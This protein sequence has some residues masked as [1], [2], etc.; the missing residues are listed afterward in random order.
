MPESNILGAG[1]WLY[2]SLFASDAAEEA[3]LT[4]LKQDITL[5]DAQL[6]S[7]AARRVTKVGSGL[8][9]AIYGGLVAPAQSVGQQIGRALWSGINAAAAKEREARRLFG[10]DLR[11]AQAT[12]ITDPYEREIAQARIEHDR[13]VAEA[14]TQKARTFDEWAS[15][16]GIDL[17]GATPEQREAA[18]ARY[19]RE[20]P[21]L[22]TG[23]LDAALAQEIANIRERQAAEKRIADLEL[24]KIV[25]EATL[26]GEALH[27]ARTAIEKQL[28]AAEAK[29]R[30]TSPEDA[31]RRR[32][33][34]QAVKAKSIDEQNAAELR[35]ATI[36]ATTTGKARERALLEEERAQAL[37]RARESGGDIGVVN[38]L[39]DARAKKLEQSDKP[40][41]VGGFGGAS[42]GLLGPNGPMRSLADASKS[43][44]KAMAGLAMVAAGAGKALLAFGGPAAAFQALNATGN[45]EAAKRF[46]ALPKPV[47]SQAT[48]AALRAAQA[49][50]RRQRRKGKTSVREWLFGGLPESGGAKDQA[51]PAA[52][53]QAAAG[54]RPNE[55][56]GWMVRVER[57]LVGI[58]DKVGL[59]FQ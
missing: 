42:L 50:S 10:G 29:A 2:R 58:S 49:A 14:R 56:E 34:E 11:R 59:Q 5:I 33:A 57:N 26:T 37:K 9:N 19:E 35:R 27:K 28:A 31:L 4:R 52:G 18:R 8:A 23:L 6:A 47:R 24:Q 7:I 32:E 51:A 46:D 25:A 12:G 48:Q 17:K 3:T 22:P 55:I 43:A 21:G 38:R 16:G 13:R 53:Q 1:R 40:G 45:P 15:A 41:T 44:G 20:E 30:G 39:F 54:P 36:E